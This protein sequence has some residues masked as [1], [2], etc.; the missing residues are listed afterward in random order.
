MGFPLLYIVGGGQWGQGCGDEGDKPID[1]WCGIY[2]DRQPPTTAWDT[3]EGVE[4]SGVGEQ[5]DIVE[6][7][8]VI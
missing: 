6:V 7:M 5:S 8:G 2:E 3:G 1:R 4:D